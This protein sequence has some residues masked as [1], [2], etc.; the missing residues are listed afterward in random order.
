M[1]LPLTAPLTGLAPSTED[2]VSKAVLVLSG[3][4]TSLPDGSSARHDYE[5]TVVKDV[6]RALGC[7][8]E[9]LRL[10][11][12]TPGAGSSSMVAHVDILP[13]A[14]RSGLEQSADDLAA[15]LVAQV[16]DTSSQLHQGSITSRI[17]RGET[18]GMLAVAVAG[19]R[20]PAARPARARPSNPPAWR[21]R[22]DAH[23]GGPVPVESSVQVRRSVQA[24][25]LAVN[26]WKRVQLLST[27]GGWRGSS[28]GNKT[29]R[30][31]HLQAIM[32]WRQD[33]IARALVLWWRIAVSMKD[34]QA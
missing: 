10:M 28:G 29:G 20:V 24:V 22:A 19:Q 5:D 3:D 27:L 26:H 6:A 9:R 11:A 18:L 14:T 31:R 15:H 25:Y 33:K 7:A 34:T 1:L 2:G 30:L 13:P 16:A 17:I 21:S 8:P 23:E 12:L 32:R 4:L